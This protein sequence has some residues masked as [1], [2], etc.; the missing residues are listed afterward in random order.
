MAKRTKRWSKHIHVEQGGLNGWCDSC[1]VEDRHRSIRT[2]VREDGYATA[3]RRLNFLANVAN[4]QDNEKLHDVAREDEAW[5]RKQ[6][7]AG[8]E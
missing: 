3:I 6:H 2:T 7:E 5:L 1:S 8:K 4:R